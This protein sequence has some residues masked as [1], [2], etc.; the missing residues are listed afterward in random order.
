MK[1]NFKKFLLL[2]LVI[3]SMFSMSI[4]AS[5]VYKTELV[6]GDYHSIFSETL[7]VSSDTAVI[8]IRSEGDGKY[9]AVAVGEGTATVSNMKWAGVSS[10]DLVFTVKSSPDKFSWPLDVGDSF[11]LAFSDKPYVSSD[12]SVVEIH[13][14][15]GNAYTA[16]AVGEGE[17]I[18]TGGSLNGRS[19][20]IYV[21]TVGDGKNV[22]NP[23]NS[24]NDSG[25]IVPDESEDKTNPPEKDSTTNQENG[26]TNQ[27]NSTTN[28]ENNTSNKDD[29]RD[30]NWIFMIIIPIA[31]L[32]LI[33]YIYIIVSMLRL[34][35]V[36]MKKKILPAVYTTAN[37]IT[38]VSAGRKTYIVPIKGKMTA[39]K[40]EQTVN[41][42]FA[43]NPYVYNCKIK[44]ETKTSL[45]SLFVG[46]KFFVKSASIEYSVSDAPQ[47]KQYAM[48]FIY[49]FRLFGSI[50]YSEEKHIAKWKE[51]NPNCVVLSKHGGRIQHFSTNGCF[52][53]QYYNY[54]FFSKDSYKE[55][56]S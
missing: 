4:T 35:S 17:A 43:E 44:L 22:V 13:S 54:V 25:N 49:K 56:L 52:W 23:D 20:L 15:G 16:I 38:D 29:D 7:P 21:L 11:S 41:E 53:A 19:N 31:I 33:L 10:S 9:I 3:V 6:I 32:L 14:E 18:I 24:N 36:S 30:M 45:L 28:Q 26:T 5:A 47:K 27:E 1:N 8:E 55:Y 39:K 37:T 40:F 48:A 51:N 2:A 12:T 42:W 50:G 34:S 46:Y